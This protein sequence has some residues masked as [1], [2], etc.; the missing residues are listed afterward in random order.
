MRFELINPYNDNTS[1]FTSKMTVRTNQVS[2]RYKKNLQWFSFFF[3]SI[4]IIYAMLCLSKSI[5]LD[6][7]VNTFIF[8]IVF[9]YITLILSIIGFFMYLYFIVNWK[10]AW[11][12]KKLIKLPTTYDDVEDKRPYELYESGSNLT[13]QTNFYIN[14]IDNEIDKTN[15]LAEEMK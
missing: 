3:A 12:T 14:R 5:K 13:N 11:M 8:M 6:D 15:Y 2:L 1:N 4:L 9:A 7:T 10:W